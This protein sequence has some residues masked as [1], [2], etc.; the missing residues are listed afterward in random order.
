MLTLQATC[1]ENPRMGFERWWRGLSILL[2]LSPEQ[3]LWKDAQDWKQA[4]DMNCFICYWRHVLFYLLLERWYVGT[5]SCCACRANTRMDWERWCE[6]G[7]SILPMLWWSST[8]KSFMGLGPGW[9]SEFFLLK[10]DMI[11]NNLIH[12]VYKATAGP[13]N[14][15]HIFDSFVI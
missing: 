3:H 6:R 14:V 1:I 7:L 8:F 10:W 13:K 2:M 15:T 5:W 9:R 12:I 4:D 11:S